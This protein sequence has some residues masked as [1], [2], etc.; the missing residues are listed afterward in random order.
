MNP[1]GSGQDP[2]SS[3]HSAEPDGFRTSTKAGHEGNSHA[4]L[5][6]QAYGNQLYISFCILFFVAV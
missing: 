5:F 3:F 1:G 6:I 2:T 4:P